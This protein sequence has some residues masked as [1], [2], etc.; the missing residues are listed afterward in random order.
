MSVLEAA[1]KVAGEFEYAPE[2]VNRGVK[3]FLNQM[4]T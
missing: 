1:N 3:E 2:D 4:R